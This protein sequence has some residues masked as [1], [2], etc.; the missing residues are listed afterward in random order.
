MNLNKAIAVFNVSTKCVPKRP[1][2]M[3]LMLNGRSTDVKMTEKQDLQ[4][5]MI[6]FN[7]WNQMYLNSI[8]CG[9]A[10]GII[11]I[12]LE[13]VILNQYTYRHEWILQIGAFPQSC[14]PLMAGKKVVYWNPASLIAKLHGS[15]M[16]PTWVLSSPSGLHLGP[17]NLDIWDVNW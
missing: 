17:M 15:N 2:T 6:S 10:I 14:S 16:G 5:I 11:N 4:L 12:L 8:V 1:S 3:I 7:K 13:K 9:N